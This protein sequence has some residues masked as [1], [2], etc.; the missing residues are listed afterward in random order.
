[1]KS[2]YQYLTRQQGKY[3]K[4]KYRMT[5]SLGR[6]HRANSWLVFR[7]GNQTLAS[8]FLTGSKLRFTDAARKLAHD[9]IRPVLGMKRL[10]K[11][12]VR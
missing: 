6:G 11:R 1:M 4:V 9:T 12:E 5:K 8:V 7:E 3:R 2:K 10:M